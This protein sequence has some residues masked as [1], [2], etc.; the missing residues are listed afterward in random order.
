MI[1]GVDAS[2]SGF[3][4]TGTGRYITCLLEQIKNS[5]NEIKIF[6][7]FQV[8]GRELGEKTKMNSFNKKYEGLKRHYNRMFNMTHEMMKLKVDCGI[9]P[10]YFISNNFYKPAAIVI[11]DLSFITHPQFYCKTF[12]NYYKYLLKQTL[13]R[14]PLILAV[15][16]H[17]KENIS[18]YLNIKKENI[19]LLQAYSYIKN[20]S[21]HN[22]GESSSDTPYFLYVGHIEP[23]K[24]ILFL[25]ENFLKWKREAKINISLKLVGE[26]WIKS[27]EI[28]YLLKKYY[29]HPDIEFEGY[30][31]ENELDIYYKNALGFVHTSLEEGF[32]FPI[33]EAMNYGLPILC[34]NNHA[35]REIS[36]PFSIL[37]DPSNN[38]NFIKGLSDLYEKK[39]NNQSIKYNIK[40]SP[41]LMQNQLINVLD[42]LHSK[43]NK[44]F[45]FS[46]N[47]VISY[48]EAIEKTLLYSHL[49]NG[50][51]HKNDLYK[52][53]F[54]IKISEMQ[55]EKALANLGYLN[56]INFKNDN[57]SLNYHNINIYKKE[58]K[59]LD[60]RKIK[61]SLLLIKSIPFISSICFSGGTA[62]YG[63]ENHDDIDLFIITRPNSVYIV[64]L[65][66][67]VLS[68]IFNLR[69]QLCANFLIDETDLEIK[70]QHDYYT[71]HQIVSLIPYKD[72][73]KLGQFRQNNYWVKNFF[74]NYI[75]QLSDKNEIIE[76]PN[77]YY[78]LLKPINILLKHI[79]RIFYRNYL[80]K[81]FSEAIKLEDKC[82]KLYT[83]DHRIRILEAFNK[84]WIKYLD[85]NK[86]MPVMLKVTGTY[87]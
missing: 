45:Y 29:N 84:E 11:H 25:V 46:F 15:S 23:R 7:S 21:D 75:T 30:V 81:D 24:N 86:R 36:S 34:S 4:F 79:Y 68:K 35:A 62:N 16:E 5:D 38:E 33:L 13:K 83:N 70:D 82:I 2:A 63:I 27:K 56:R 54:D 58:T 32:G 53:L 17:T 22:K 20:T 12:V 28:D 69:K 57:V 52:F 85:A 67:H 10:N 59:Y 77:K 43:V 40:Y 66:V 47:K 71:A 14:N 64:Y 78:L 65:I 31:S 50:G 37:I 26:L 3:K 61:K 72:S 19:L 76:T 18:T 74:P 44:K 73:Q 41:E 1:I 42:I 6:P 8:T 51:L 48:E 60:K 39:I 87:D 55:F 80:L 9:F 49:F